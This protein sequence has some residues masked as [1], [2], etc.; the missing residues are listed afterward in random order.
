MIKG[1]DQEII[2]GFKL[3]KCDLQIGSLSIRGSTLTNLTNKP[4]NILN[5][6][7]LTI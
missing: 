2:T 6:S 3:C 7:D 1:D 4:M 5:G